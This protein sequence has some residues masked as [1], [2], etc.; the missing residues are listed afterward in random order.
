M[1]G[2][3]DRRGSGIQQ[4]RKV[5]GAADFFQLPL[6]LETIGYRDKVYGLGFVKQ[7][8]D[9]NENFLMGGA[10]K[11]FRCQNLDDVQQC[12]IIPENGA[13]DGLLSFDVLRW[14]SVGYTFLGFLFRAFGHR[15]SFKRGVPLFQS[16]NPLF[17][18]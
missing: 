7:I 1:M 15:S 17:H 12:V 5:T 18:V 16:I 13:D 10:I 14:K 3:I 8:D 2:C 11:V 9:G 4:T 6:F